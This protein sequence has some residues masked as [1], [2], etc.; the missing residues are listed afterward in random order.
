MTPGL[1]NR[2]PYQHAAASVFRAVKNKIS[3]ICPAN[4]GLS[5][6]IYRNGKITKSVKDPEGKEIFITGIKTCDVNVAKH[7]T[8]Y[9][10]Y[11]NLFIFIC[12]GVIIY[13]FSQKLQNKYL[14]RKAQ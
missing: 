7:K 5:C 4:T 1:Q 9:A 13:R 6:F 3:L 8:F 10:K 12:F 14:F 11:G 2:A